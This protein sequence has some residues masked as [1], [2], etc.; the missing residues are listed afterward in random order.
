[1]T[2]LPSLAHQYFF[3]SKKYVALSVEDLDETLIHAAIYRKDAE[4]QV[5]TFAA[6]VRREMYMN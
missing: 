1:M 5:R 2:L 6:M 3:N 4:E